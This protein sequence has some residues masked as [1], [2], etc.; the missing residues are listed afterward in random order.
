MRVGIELH[1]R[2]GGGGSDIKEICLIEKTLPFSDFFGEKSGIFSFSGPTQQA[3]FQEQTVSC[4]L[5]K[6][7][8]GHVFLEKCT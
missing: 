1:G 4:F 6:L 5:N 2:V 3:C 8:K 7:Q